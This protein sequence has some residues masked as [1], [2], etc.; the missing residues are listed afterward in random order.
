[1]T[2]L[3]A[4]LS[5]AIL[6]LAIVA[7]RQEL[8]VAGLAV[9]I[10]LDVLDGYLARRFQAE[11]VFGAQLDGLADRLAATLVLGGAVFID[12]ST[13]VAIAALVVWV[14]YGLV[15]QF[16]N[17]QFLRFGLWSPDHFHL[18]DPTTWRLTWSAPSKIAS[19]GSVALMALGLPWE[20][21]GLAV[22]LIAVRIASAPRILAAARR[23]PE[24]RPLVADEVPAELLA[25]LPS[26]YLAVDGDGAR[27]LAGPSSGSQAQEAA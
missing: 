18:E 27:N 12:P 8:L 23:L 21:L 6:V 2:L 22:V 15:E 10:G 9:S 26:L 13:V 3:R 24:P 4:V 20:A 25:I 17:V 5:T 19:G 16:L 14:Q 11:T 1:V 7:R